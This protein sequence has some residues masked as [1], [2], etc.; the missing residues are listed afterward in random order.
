ME[1]ILNLTS[2]G[3]EGSEERAIINIVPRVADSDFE[4]YYA[5]KYYTETTL[6]EGLTA[7]LFMCKWSIVNTNAPSGNKPLELG[8]LLLEEE[9]DY[10]CRVSIEN[11]VNGDVIIEFYIDGPNLSKAINQPFLRY[12]DDT[13]YKISSSEYGPAFIHDSRTVKDQ[14]GFPSK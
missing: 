9:I 7:N 6:I 4:K 8:Y 10:K 11:D 3:N 5:V 14:W 13:E 1:F 12:V 2:I